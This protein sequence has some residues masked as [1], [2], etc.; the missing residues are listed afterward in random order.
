MSQTETPTAVRELATHGEKI[1]NDSPQRFPE[2]G[3]PGDFV[4]QGDVYI[5]L[6]DR[7]PAKA[8]KIEPRPQL[9]PGNT[10][11]SRH[12]LDKLT[13]IEMYELEQPSAYDGP[14]LSATEEVTVT[15]PEH[16]NWILPPGT[17]GI[18]Y[19][20]TGESED[21]ARRVQD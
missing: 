11:G 2:A 19:Q 15:H 13:G 18:T 17:Y 1:K 5:T 10:Q 21:R 12:C 4:R 3:S 20:R 9:A 16:G 6:L 14:V 8:K 7:V